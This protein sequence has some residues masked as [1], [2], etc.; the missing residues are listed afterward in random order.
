MNVDGFIT[1][2]REDSL[3]ISRE[4]DRPDSGSPFRIGRRKQTCL[5]IP[6]LTFTPTPILICCYP[7][8]IRRDSKLPYATGY[9]RNS[10]NPFYMLFQWTRHQSTVVRIPNTDITNAVCGD[11]SLCS[12]RECH[13]VNGSVM[14]FQ[15]FMNGVQDPKTNILPPIENATVWIHLVHPVR[16]PTRR[17]PVCAFHTQILLPWEPEAI[18]LPSEKKPRDTNTINR[19]CV[20]FDWSCDHLSSHSIPYQNCIVIRTQGNSSAVERKSNTLYHIAVLSVLPVCASQ[21][22]IKRS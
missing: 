13:E 17:S 16:G 2:G 15:R 12:E 14:A 20:P 7:L 22:M 19:T 9:K 11:N 8:P 10:K 6:D 21:T 5:W 4:K 3:A 1:R 18:H